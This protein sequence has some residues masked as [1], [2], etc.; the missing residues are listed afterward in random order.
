MYEESS[1]EMKD[2]GPESDD[3]YLTDVYNK[4]NRKVSIIDF[5]SAPPLLKV[6][7]NMSL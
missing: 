3:K 5:I 1:N 2:R 6:V 7:L 4:L